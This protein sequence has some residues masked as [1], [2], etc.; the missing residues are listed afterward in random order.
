ML[1]AKSVGWRSRHH[2]RSCGLIICDNC[3]SPFEFRLQKWVSST[4][5]HAIKHDDKGKSKK[6]CK[7]C[8]RILKQKQQE[9][10]TLTVN[11]GSQPHLTWLNDNFLK[12]VGKSSYWGGEVWTAGYYTKTGSYRVTLTNPEEYPN[13]SNSYT[14]TMGG[15]EVDIIGIWQSNDRQI[16]YEL[17]CPSDRASQSGLWPQ[18]RTGWIRADNIKPTNKALHL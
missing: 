4:T 12:A 10:K 9:E 5:G 2:C 15:R 11:E 18:D 13:S 6:V 16:W 17:R 7:C 1:C 8:F 3:K 14:Q